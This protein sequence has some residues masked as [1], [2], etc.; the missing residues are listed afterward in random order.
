MATFLSEMW[1]L[2]II[3]KSVYEKKN[4]NGQTKGDKK[5]FLRK[6]HHDNS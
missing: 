4:N 2:I 1:V 5:T 6:G 3:A